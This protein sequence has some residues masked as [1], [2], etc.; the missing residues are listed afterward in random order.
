M[1]TPRDAG[2]RAESTPLSSEDALRASEARFRLLITKNVDGVVVVGRDGVIQFVNPAAEN[3][4]A[5]TTADLVG[6]PFGFPMVVGETTELDIVRRPDD[7]A[8]AEMRVVATEWE[9]APALLASLRDISERKRAEE[10]LRQQAE[11]LRQVQKMEAVGQLTSGMAHEFNN[12]LTAILGYS[13]LLQRG[14]AHDEV[15]H[16][17]VTQIVDVSGRAASLIQ[18]LLAFAR[19]QVLK[20]QILDCNAIV[21]ETEDILRPVLGER[22]ELI[23]RLNPRLG[24]VEAD[25]VQLQQ[26][27]VNLLVNA[28]DAMPEGG[29]LRLETDNVVLDA[30]QNG[31]YLNAP[32]GAYVRLMVSDTG[33]GMES[34]VLAHLFEPFFTTKEI[35]KGTG[36]GLAVVYGIVQQNGGDIEVQSTPAAGATFKIYLPRVTHDHNPISIPEVDVISPLGSETVLLVEDEATVRVLMRSALELKGYQVLEAADAQEAIK[37]CE[38]YAEPIH[39]LVADIVMPGMSGYEL[40]ELLTSLYPAMRTLMISGHGAAAAE[41]ATMTSSSA[42]FL[43]KPFT[44]DELAYHARAALDP[45]D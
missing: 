3:L 43:S 14:L 7:I 20:P 25:P 2:H 19:Q 9:G 12:L 23:K 5:R 13:N 36:L 16:G 34:E 21:Y 28:R 41:H 6:Q 4:F 33:V 38:S 44:M 39:L 40:A 45:P 22:I 30:G 15:M 26:L 24:A 1:V 27:L 29:K 10:M 32:P 18:Q 8:V 17:Y 37:L 35:G 31:R 42:V 11:Q